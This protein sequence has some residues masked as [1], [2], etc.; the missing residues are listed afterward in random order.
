MI[1]VRRE[2]Q[3]DAGDDISL[4]FFKNTLGENVGARVLAGFMAI[5]SLGNIIV[6]TFTMARVKQEIA[7]EGIVPYPKFFAENSDL[8]GYLAKRRGV[9]SSF[10][11]P[12]PNGALLL[13]WVFTVLLI[14][15]TWPQ[16]RATD[17]YAI[18]VSIY[19]YTVHAFIFFVLAFGLLCLRL[20]TPSS[21]TPWRRKSTFSHPLSIIS[22]AILALATAFPLIVYWIP[23][24]SSSS[25]TAIDKEIEEALISSYPWYSTPVISWSLLGFAVVYWACFR[26]VLP[27]FGNRKGKELI[28][29][30]RPFLR[31]EH[32][33]YIQWHE[34]VD[35]HWHLK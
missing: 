18:I 28:A 22:A 1:V 34:V 30:R 32:G 35:F 12:T 31:M 11:E 23:P 7:K 9:I 15:A 16:D 2:D 20:Y 4:Q 3:I 21:K 24:S 29:E 13:H 8:I 14:F 10:S 33:Y 17:S 5:S 6:T 26:Y 19:S 25:D 27:Q